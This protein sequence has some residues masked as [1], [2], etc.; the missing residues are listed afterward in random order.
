MTRRC[1]LGAIV[2]LLAWSGQAAEYW[3][4]VGTFTGPTSKGI[5][6][7]RFDASTGKVTPQGL[8][9]ETEHPS[10]LAVDPN[11]RFLFAAHGR[12]TM[13]GSYAIDASTGKL[14]LIDEV[15]SEGKNPVFVLVDHTGKHL[16][17][18]N[19]DSGT[20]AVLPIGADGRLGKAT[21]IIQ[22]HGKSGVNAERQ[23]GPHPHNLAL[24]SDNRFVLVPDL[25][26][27]Q[28]LV[29][30]FDAAHGTLTPNDPPFARIAPG[31]GPRHIAFHPNGK[32]VYIVSELASTLTAYA[33]DPSSGALRQVQ[34][35]SSL[36][37][38]FKGQSAAAEVQVNRAGTVLYASN[39]GHDS[40]AMFSI[41]RRD[42]T[43]TPMGT[44]PSGGK[45][46]RYFCLD[47]SGRFLLAGDQDSN[48]VVEFAVD[49]KSGKLSPAT[50]VATD[51]GSPVAIAF[52]PK[53]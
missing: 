19:Y 45:T 21:S 43:L 17:V 41:N 12:Q 6:G 36:P 23:A 28:V 25:G 48:L 42:F 51:A 38:D 2:C 10:L 53:K 16:L 15:P 30:R 46:P 29:Y 33:F 20:L 50:T 34:S 8:A 13:V 1:A 35:I 4:Y 49:P 24:T 5:Y 47:P 11:G 52:A 27:D 14:T 22:H 7:Y 26:L 31:S 37:A 18:A 3:M 44:V 9:A 32:M 39:R 40:I